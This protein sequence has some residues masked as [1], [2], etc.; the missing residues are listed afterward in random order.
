M[1]ALPCV[2]LRCT[3]RLLLTLVIETLLTYATT[4]AFYIHLCALPPQSRPDLTT[5][6]ILP[7]LLQLKEGVTMLEDLDFAA[8]SDDEG[9]KILLNG[10]MEDSGEEQDAE[11]KAAPSNR[12]RKARPFADEEDD[13]GDLWQMEGLEDGELEGLLADADERMIAKSSL[14]GLRAETKKRKRKGR[15]KDKKDGIDKSNRRESATNGTSTILVEPAFFSS[16]SK[17]HAD[18]M[19]ND[20]DDDVLGDPTTLA[21]ADASDKARRKRSLRFHTSKISATSARRSAARTQRLGGDED[22]PYRDRKAGRDAAL[23]KNGPEPSEGEALDPMDRQEGSRKNV[24]MVISDEEN[25]E[26]YYDLVKRRRTEEKA[27]KEAERRAAQEAK[28]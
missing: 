28:L 19:E 2:G 25:G 18:L 3:V 23:R 5:H 13:G 11:G 1:A 9:I 15:A 16:S 17:T 7:R 8:G 14:Q 21:D 27:T 22:L 12:K 20:S 10:D 4:L 24:D 26:G 6:P